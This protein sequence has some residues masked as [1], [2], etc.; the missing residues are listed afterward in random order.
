MNP[1]PRL[2]N[3]SKGLEK[4]YACRNYFQP[5]GS[6]FGGDNLHALN[7]IQGAQAS[8]DCAVLDCTLLPAGHHHCARAAAALLATE[9]QHYGASQRFFQDQSPAARNKQALLTAWKKA[10]PRNAHLATAELRPGQALLCR[11]IQQGASLVVLRVWLR[12]T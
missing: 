4:L 3:C 6:T 9:R 2:T 5:V 7:G 1:R 12:H 8:V 10:R 11:Q